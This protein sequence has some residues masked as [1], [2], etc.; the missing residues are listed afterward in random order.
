M[1]ENKVSVGDE[2]WIEFI[3]SGAASDPQKIFTSESYFYAFWELADHGV[4]IIDEAGSIVDANPAF[5]NMVH[6]DISEITSMKIKDLL[7]NI[8][9][10]QDIGLFTSVIKG[11][12]KNFEVEANINYEFKDKKQIPVKIIACRIPTESGRPFNHFIVQ[13]YDRRGDSL[14][15][16]LAEDYKNMSWGDL[17]KKTICEHF[18]SVILT[19]FSFTL[20]LALTGD[21]GAVI[22]KLIDKSPAIQQSEDK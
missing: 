15:N 1:A 21:L 17:A 2:S 20:I 16:N 5:L 9:Y 4:L 10:K 18:T 13:I 14:Y 3:Q 11:A 22:G 12:K 6:S 19:I 7:P 8:E